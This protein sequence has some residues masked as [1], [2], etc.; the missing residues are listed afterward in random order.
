MTDSIIAAQAFVFFLAGFETSSTTMSNALYELALNI[1]IQ[2]KLRNEIH[3]E[4]KKND[5]KLTY[6]SVKHMTYLDEIFNGNNRI[7]VG[8]KIANKSLQMIFCCHL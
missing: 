4:L 1:S 2:D 5:G 3:N 6:E 7:T 8:N